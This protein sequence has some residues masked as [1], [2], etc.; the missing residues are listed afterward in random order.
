MSGISIGWRAAGGAGRAQLKVVV[1]GGTSDLQIQAQGDHSSG[2]AIDGGGG[3]RQG[4]VGIDGWDA[5]ATR[6]QTTASR[7]GGDKFGVR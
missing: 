5:A 4:W 2:L 7:V 1:R 3:F 6:D